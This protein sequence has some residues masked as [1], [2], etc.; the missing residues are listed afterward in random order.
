[1]LGSGGVLVLSVEKGR[2]AMTSGQ[3][4]FGCGV[5][6]LGLTVLT[7]IV[8]VLKKPKY[9]PGNSIYESAEAVHMQPFRNGYPT[10]KET[11]R[12]D[13]P[14]FYPGDP[15]EL[16]EAEGAERKTA[17]IFRTAVV[18]KAAEVCQL[19]ETEILPTTEEIE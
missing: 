11:I 2:I 7:A 9:I 5:V 16:A 15:A 17:A 1:M 4:V 19:E 6:L 8:F 10:E 3:L 13:L 14:S 18:G 12:R